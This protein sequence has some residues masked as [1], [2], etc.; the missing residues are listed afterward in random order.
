M[1][2][3]ETVKLL[4]KKIDTLKKNHNLSLGIGILGVI[5]A[6]IALFK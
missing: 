3:N 5:L 2:I 6:I 4:E 1:N